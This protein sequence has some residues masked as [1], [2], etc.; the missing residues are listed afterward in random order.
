MDVGSIYGIVTLII[1]LIFSAIFSGSEVALFSLDEK[2]LS[3]LKS[4]SNLIGKYISALLKF[5]RRLLVTILIGNTIFNVAASIISVSLALKVADAY[6]VE[7]DIALI[8]QIFLLTIIVIIFAEITPKV[9]ANKHPLKFSKIIAFPLYW[10]HLIISPI[11][12][13]LTSF[14]NLLTSNIKIDKSK[15]ALSNVEIA[16]LANI[17]IEKGTIEEDEHELLR[18]LESFGT[19]L[20]REVMTPRVDVIAVHHNT[21]LKDLLKIINE[22]GKS[23]LPVYEDDLDNIL[24]IIYAK[25]MLPYLNKKDQDKNFP[26]KSIM[27]ESSFVPETKLISKQMQ[28]F[29]EKKTH[30]SI[31]VDEYGGTAGVISLEDILEEIVGEI[32]DE[33]DTDENEFTKLKENKFQ[34]LGKLSM[35]EVEEL[36]DISLDDS[37]EDYDTLAGYILNHAGTI[38]EVGYSFEE[39]G[40]KFLVTDVSDKRIHKVEVEKLSNN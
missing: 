34:V 22:S 32:R 25:D 30:I 19:M 11:S 20:V 36:F 13:F 12:T 26:I 18:G 10:T 17:G 40:L 33:H 38:P 21:S 31:V 29:Q 9:W 15:N 6:N 37:E 35:D 8:V 5:P 16:E 4:S 39:H 1:L 23:R 14:I 7:Y 2:R 3:E 24:G 27:R 28:E